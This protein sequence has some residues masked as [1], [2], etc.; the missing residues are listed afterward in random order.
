MTNWNPLFENKTFTDIVI[1]AGEKEV[2]AHSD[3]LAAVF[4]NETAENTED[5]LK[6]LTSSTRCYSRW[7]DS[8]TVVR[9][10]QK[11]RWPAIFH[12]RTSISWIIWSTRVSWLARW[13]GSL[14]TCRCWQARR[15]KSQSRHRQFHYSTRQ[16][17]AEG[18]WLDTHGTGVFRTRRWTF[19][20][21]HHLEKTTSY[22][23]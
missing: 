15:K 12:L 9:N 18:G 11:A 6:F 22:L 2:R 14:A 7:Y 3:L 13:Y 16:T 17:G 4:G 1:V 23:S 19:L 10:H 8:C 5:E 21:C 20:G